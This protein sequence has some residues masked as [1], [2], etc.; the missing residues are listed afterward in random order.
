MKQ[1]LLQ[2]RPTHRQTLPSRYQQKNAYAPLPFPSAL[3]LFSSGYDQTNLCSLQRRRQQRKGRGF[4]FPRRRE[5]EQRSPCR[6]PSVCTA[7]G[8]LR[9]RTGNPEWLPFKALSVNVSFEKA[10]VSISKES[11][12]SSMTAARGPENYQRRRGRKTQ[13]VNIGCC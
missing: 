11:H 6:K 8:T 4:V 1:T 10:V 2:Y 3:D 5:E 12:D 7:A 13:H 9:F